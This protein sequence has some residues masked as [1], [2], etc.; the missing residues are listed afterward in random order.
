MGFFGDQRSPTPPLGLH[1]DTVGGKGQVQ[2][3][4]T[5]LIGHE[6]RRVHTTGVTGAIGMQPSAGLVRAGAGG[7]T[8]PERGRSMAVD[9]PDAFHEGGLLPRLSCA[10]R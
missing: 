8:F 7:A 6:F 9:P 5:P 10:V 2:G 1:N 4:G 3:V